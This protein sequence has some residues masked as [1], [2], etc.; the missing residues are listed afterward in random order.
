MN[1][2][3]IPSTFDDYALNTINQEYYLVA[4]SH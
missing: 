3:D 2:K 1:Y 4:N